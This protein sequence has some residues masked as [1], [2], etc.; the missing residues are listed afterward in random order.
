V[1]AVRP[2]DL[3]A[4]RPR[5]GIHQEHDRSSV[6]A[7]STFAPGKAIPELLRFQVEEE[8]PTG[9]EGVSSP[10]TG[11]LADHHR[12]A[13]VL[14]HRHDSF[15]SR[16][17]ELAHSTPKGNTVNRSSYWSALLQTYTVPTPLSDAAARRRAAGNG[18]SA[19]RQVTISSGLGEILSAPTWGDVSDC[20]WET[21]LEA[22]WALVLNR[23]SRED[24]VSFGEVVPQARTVLPT[25]VTIPPGEAVRA[26]LSSV[27]KARSERLTHADVSFVELRSLARDPA[28][29]EYF[30]SILV[31]DGAPEG[32]LQ[33]SGSTFAVG[34]ST[35]RTRLIADFATA[36]WDDSSAERILR[37]WAAALR[38]LASK[39]ELP[40]KQLS[41]LDPRDHEDLALFNAT[42]VQHPA[43]K[44]VHQLVEEQVSRSGS[45]LAIVTEQESLTYRELNRRANQLAHHLR[46]LGVT[47]DTLVGIS[48][49][50]SSAMCVGVL[51]I[52][53]SGGAYVP[54]DPSYPS[55]R[56]DFMLQDAS[57]SV[58]LLDQWTAPKLGDRTARC[59]M[60]DDPESYDGFSDTD[61]ENLAT[62]ESLAYVIY[63]S[64]S[65]G[66]PKGVLVPHSSVV[67][68]VSSVARVPG[69]SATDVVLAIT[70]LSFDISVSEILLPL[71]VGAKIV[72]ADRAT[73]T[74]GVALASLMER[75]KV[76][77]VDATPATYR[78][79]LSAGWKGNSELTLICTGEAMPGDLAERLLACGRSVWNGYGPTETTV[80]SSFW[81]VPTNF[82][83]VLIGRPVDNTRFYVVDPDGG[84]LPVGMAGE[85][86]IAGAGVTC[87]YLNRPE[88]TDERFVTDPFT[89][90]SQRMY[91]TGDI[92]RFL[93]TGELECLGRN[94][95]QVK[96]R[97]YR[98]ELG[99]IESAI[100]RHP[101]VKQAVVSLR[102]DRPSEPRLV[103]YI[104]Y[105]SIPVASGEM[106]AHLKRSLP[107][108][109]VPAMYVQLE[110][111]P[112]TPSGKVD[113]RSLPPPSHERPD[114]G[115]VALPR[116]ELE[117]TICGVFSQLL[118]FEQVGATD[119]FFD[120]GGNS[121]LSMRVLGELREKHGIDIPVA[122]FFQL[123]TAR[124]LEGFLKGQSHA[125]DNRM[126]LRSRQVGDDE[127]VAIIGM[128]GR[129]PGAR[130][131]ATLWRNIC[132]G[133]DSI[134]YFGKAGLDPSLPA[135]LGED[136]S[137]IKARGTI[138]DHD[139][140]DA[141]FFGVNPKD[142]ELIDPQQRLLLEVSWEALE[143]AGYVPENVRGLVGVFAGMYGNTYM[144]E[145]L[146][147]HPELEER[148]GLFGL[149]V[150]N[151][152][153]YAATRIAHRL[154]LTGPAVSVHTACSTSLVAVVEAFHSLR[155]GQCDLALAGA[156]SV[157]CPVR[158]GYW[159]V[160]GGMLSA[161]G[162]TRTFDADASGTTFNDGVAMLVLKRLS[163]AIADNDTIYGVIRG[164]AIN[165]DGGEKASFTAPSVAGQSAV[166]R[167]AQ[168]VA[169]VDARSISYIEAHG[170]A[171]PLGDPIEIEALTEAFRASTDDRQFCAISSIKSNIGHLVS[172][173]GAAG[174]IK[175]ALSITNGVIPPTAHFK[176]A[177]PKIDFEST[178]FYVADRLMEWPAV[179]AP[180]RAGV[181]SFGVGGTNAHVIVEQGPEPKPSSSLR[182]RQL[183]LLSARTKSALERAT[184]NLASH[185]AEHSE[186]NL[187]DVASTLMRG[188]RAFVERRFAVADSVASAAQALSQPN[189]LPTRSLAGDEPRVAF[190]FPGQGAQFPNM[191]RSLYRDEA[192]FRTVVDECA[193]RLL[194]ELGVDLRDVLYP[195]DGGSL[196]SAAESLR[197]TAITQPALFTVEYAMAQVLL[198]WGVRPDAMVGHS[199]GEYVCAALAG[200]MSL[201][202]ALK[203]VAARGR[204]MQ[205][206]AP[207]AML[208]VRLAASALANRLPPDVAIAS[209]NAPSL[210]VVSGPSGSIASLQA[211]LES[212]GITCRQLVTSH[213]FHSAMMDPVL[214]PF[215]D[216]VRQVRLE[217]PKLRYVSTL[218]GTWVRPEEA[219]DPEYWAKHL[220][221]TVNFSA[222]ASELLRDPSRVLVEVG[223]RATL[224]TLARQQSADPAHLVAVPT[225]GDH[226]EESAD[227]TGVLQAVGHLWMA[228]VEFDWSSFY[229][230]EQ[231][232]RVALPTYPFERRR[233]WVEP[234]AVATTSTQSNPT[235]TSADTR[236]VEETSPPQEAGSQSVVVSRI[237]RLVTRLREVFEE[238]SGFE[239][240]AV[241]EDTGFMELGLDSLSLTQVALQL[242]KTFGVRV[243]FRELME[244]YPS[245]A[246]LA[247]HLDD[248]LPLER[249]EAPKP[250]PAPLQVGTVANA[251]ASPQVSA[252]QAPLLQGTGA[253]SVDQG[254][255]GVIDRQLLIMQQQLALLSGASLSSA[256]SLAAALRADPAPAPGIGSEQPGRPEGPPATAVGTDAD[257]DVDAPVKYDV[258]KAFGAIARITT[259]R[260]DD[261]TPQQRTRL[262]AFIRRYCERT[263]RSKEHTQEHRTVLADPRAVTGF[264]PALKELVYQIVIDRS[265]GSRVWDLD[266]NEYVDALN[267]FGASLFGWQAPFVTEAAIAQLTRGHEIGPM[268]RLAGEVAK[269]ICEFTGFDRAGF[270]NTGSE[271]V[272][273]CM[274]IART[275]TGR[276][277]IVSFNNSYHGIND[278]VIIRGTKKLKAVPAAPGIMPNTTQNMLVLDYGTE[279]S[280]AII[281][282]R[283][284]ECAAFLIEPV[285]SRRPDFQPR[286]FLRTLREIADQHG[287][288]YIFDEV[289]T[290]FRSDP[291]GAQSVFGI[292]ADLA[293]YGKVIGG[294]FPF[295]VI[296][297]RRQYM[298]ALDGGFWQYGDDSCPTVGVTYFAGT[299]CRHPLALAA[300]KA[301]LLHLKE[302]GPALQESLNTKT[303]Q[304]A[305]ELN[306]FFASV[307]APYEIRHFASLWKTF[308]TEEHPYADL[309]FYY[310]R[311]RGIH[312]LEGFPCFMT[313][314]HTDDDV[315]RIVD[316]FKSAVAELQAAE[317]IPAPPKNEAP[318][319]D[320]AK[321][322][323]AGAR[324]GRE[325]NG[326]PAWFVQD[327]AN[328]K[329]YVKYSP[330]AHGT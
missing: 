250:A 39:L 181:S 308:I 179:P 108:F 287:V 282:E 176:R 170:T 300:A 278:E 190:L 96:L 199:I 148:L 7:N 22:S 28:A 192:V 263:R 227:W 323:V 293:S 267:G 55:E 277:T 33:A 46:K 301:S 275:V 298:D 112:L 141:P 23:H 20:S 187:A 8:H 146:L 58:L 57:V 119:N 87:G 294:G 75:N 91:R 160:E 115:P 114:I 313:T 289:I 205:S 86:C 155:T 210:C 175:T 201:A 6:K 158:S 118:G 30:E 97:G 157:T 305:T 273:G 71:T 188:R 246:S 31:L 224:V 49:E 257:T 220:R 251:S 231:R 311:D 12:G 93:P 233:Y 45:A 163:D 177:N 218:T 94:D 226:A 299:F 89:P 284:G 59:L 317:F 24:T 50:R 168:A 95:Q 243:T 292:R 264:R 310:L 70:T 150:Q 111:M 107:E 230:D 78:L 200:V 123:P 266:G 283:A 35:D 208:S 269:L 53:K 165:N 43:S 302:C 16:R 316:A 13:D 134:S 121:L 217:A 66:K 9:G 149:Q 105:H 74:D 81:Q 147:T 185:L 209:E 237:P 64:G 36:L 76:T 239:M 56:L 15:P 252:S 73:T 285:Q 11:A 85:L 169:G 280:L 122:R 3:C 259:S 103:A 248:Q 240:Q 14:S 265:S 159:Y 206:M 29:I 271:A 137:Y 32:S 63:T 290:G 207:G 80:W 116:T 307:G 256:A 19:R 254:I 51:A 238:V 191:G 83:K 183:L 262:D 25:V 297:G 186:L 202:D 79:L 223:P 109:M 72:L 54:L 204:L 189:R 65:T 326:N 90:G 77:F 314:A 139:Q 296:A 104:V 117:Q 320:A 182:P 143:H 318:A 322:P 161:D 171:T 221:Q 153:D 44:C 98:I 216:L 151:E 203:L 110:K 140:F 324:L 212:E 126:P 27:E 315:K 215:A 10:V 133:V 306:A 295:G 279:E 229:T 198:G 145:N 291:G 180:R 164:A 132:A 309:I 47:R 253:P 102:E 88:L 99:E 17:S 120:L 144:T 18:G 260:G 67:N 236:P 52:L 167:Q 127:P 106:R 131:I 228:G 276:T 128:A 312:I 211:T 222:A 235:V 69:L 130:D 232:Q 213:A 129:F 288:V 34:T 274:R 152:K 327:P 270:C 242:Q 244:S 193:S 26:W 225:L 234:A 101:A 166:I 4:W 328:P 272:L 2:I 5:A 172:A 184:A 68:L 261:L 245:L 100:A 258:K 195:K 214:A 281:R 173:A 84:L 329:K 60:V 37:H 42:D 197:N 319:F 92:G 154:N 303:S 138:D 178:P 62:P 249:A 325:P 196:E 61:P 162:H 135:W 268:H 286:E 125:A 21:L 194:P 136:P 304:M 124:G 174:L 255:A 38:Q 40:T 241:S 48:V 113:R 321:P 156:A 330:D 1:T 142:A 82:T 247:A 219:I 41:L